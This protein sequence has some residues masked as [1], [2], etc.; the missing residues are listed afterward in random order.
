MSARQPAPSHRDPGD[1]RVMIEN[2]KR[3]REW[4]RGKVRAWCDA[5]IADAERELRHVV[6][7]ESS[8][9]ADYNT[10]GA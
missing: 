9:P 3:T 1:L 8:Q 4:S 5:L 6:A 2:Y 10:A 7:P